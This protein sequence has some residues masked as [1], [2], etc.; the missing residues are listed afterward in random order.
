[1]PTWQKLVVGPS[2][3]LVAVLALSAVALPGCGDDSASAGTMSGGAGD[4]D[5]ASEGPAALVGVDPSSGELR[6]HHVADD[7]RS[8]ALV[9]GVV[10][11]RGPD[12]V[13]VGLD[14]GSGE[15]RWCRRFGEVHRS[16]G[17]GW[18]HPDLLAADDL[19]ALITAAGEVVGVDPSTG[20]TRWRTAVEP[21]EGLHLISAANG[22][23]V[24]G[25]DRGEPIAVLDPDEG[26]HMDHATSSDGSLSLE[27]SSTFHEVR[28]EI[29][30]AV[31]GEDGET[32]WSSTVPGFNAQLIGDLVVVLD[33]TRG[34]GVLPEHPAGSLTLVTGYDASD[35]E[36]H[37]SIEVPGTPQE[38]FDA[39]QLMV[40]ASGSMLMAIDASGTAAWTA[41]HGSP[42]TGGAHS[43]P[44][45]YHWLS[46]DPIS[47]TIVGLILAEQPYRD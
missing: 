22:V 31:V 26:S 41:D 46:F 40:V 5:A 2:R 30:V 23:V 14:A 12:G 37:W 27:T 11:I 24:A 45:G 28:Q 36:E 13:A 44:G 3:V 10:G 7:Q 32:L 35:G 33:Q 15:R 18:V 25:G 42:G 34:T 20:E 43:L 47:N 29:A 17:A 6:W 4:W 39:G 19:F 9:G 21:T 8:A 38:V 16:E 1:V